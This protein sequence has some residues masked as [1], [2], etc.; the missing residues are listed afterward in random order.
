M[1]CH[2]RSTSIS[3]RRRR[4]FPPRPARPPLAVLDLS[5]PEERS[6]YEYIQRAT[7]GDR[8]CWRMLSMRRQGDLLLCAL[9]WARR[10]GTPKPYAV[11]EFNLAAR[12]GLALCWHE[13]ATAEAACAEM[14]RRSST[15][16]SQE[17]QP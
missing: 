3:S 14:A 2:V 9:I 12:E 11:A 10:A 13:F 17:V 1:P 16:V 6:A 15:T 5:R 7:T 4:P 8:P